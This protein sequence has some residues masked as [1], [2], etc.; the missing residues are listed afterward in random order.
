MIPEYGEHQPTADPATSEDATASQPA[1][2]G[3]TAAQPTAS[4]EATTESSRPYVK[5]CLINVLINED[6]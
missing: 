5:W 1:S 4:G 3:T 2:S 6:I